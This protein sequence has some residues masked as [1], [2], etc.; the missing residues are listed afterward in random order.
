MSERGIEVGVEKM[1][2]WRGGDT[3]VCIYTAKGQGE[4]DGGREGW[5]EEGSCVRGEELVWEL[6]RFW[7][8]WEKQKKKKKKGCCQQLL[9]GA[10]YLYAQPNT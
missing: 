4:G 1:V 9:L 10:C 6:E 3:Y 7:S 8:S 2:W 5:R